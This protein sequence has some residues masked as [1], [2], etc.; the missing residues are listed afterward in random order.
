[1]FV[2]YSHVV[3]GFP[4]TVSRAVEG[5]TSLPGALMRGGGHHTDRGAGMADAEAASLSRRRSQ[6]A[7]VTAQYTMLS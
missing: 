7:L 5:L 3:T 1:M 4:D 2:I 6:V